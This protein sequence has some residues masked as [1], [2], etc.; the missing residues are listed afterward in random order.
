M[1]IILGQGFR[2]RASLDVS[3]PT[4]QYQDMGCIV[5]FPCDP[6]PHSDSLIISLTTTHTTT[7][8]KGVELTDHLQLIGNISEI[9]ESCLKRALTQLPHGVTKSEYTNE[10][11]SFDNAEKCYSVTFKGNPLSP[12]NLNEG[13]HAK[14]TLQT[15]IN[16]LKESGW[17]L[18]I[19]TDLSTN[20][21]I[22]GEGDSKKTHPL[23]SHSLFLVKTGSQESHGM[24]F[25]APPSHAP[26]SYDMPHQLW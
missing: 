26:P 2:P 22:T 18:L 16:E 24:T 1:N 20:I 21:Y 4:G 10:L 12:G 5:F 3:R 13:I 25:D 19:S 15:L 23:D 9:E 7:W 11:D 6:I 17:S 14:V 8:S